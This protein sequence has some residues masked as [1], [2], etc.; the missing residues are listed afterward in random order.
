MRNAVGTELQILGCALS[1][2]RVHQLVNIIIMTGH[3][4]PTAEEVA[5]D[6]EPT[7]PSVEND[8]LVPEGALGIDDC[9]IGHCKVDAWNILAT[10]WHDR[11]RRIGIE[12][13]LRT[14]LDLHNFVDVIVG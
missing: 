5:P 9:D 12:S 8:D 1:N 3:T 13:R 6:L 7:A 14:G 11:P 4:V 10:I 2:L